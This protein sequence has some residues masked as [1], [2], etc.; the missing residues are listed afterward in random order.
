M[1]APTQQVAAAAP[2]V[3]AITNPQQLEACLKQLLVNDTQ[4]VKI[5]EK[6]LRQFSKSEQCLPAYLQQIQACADVGVRQLAA[7]LARAKI[8]EHWKTL[9]AS[10]KDMMKNMLLQSIVKEPVYEI[11]I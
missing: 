4:A 2:T 9:Q 1:S 11:L 7:V 6:A 10:V 3:P 8:K 5:A